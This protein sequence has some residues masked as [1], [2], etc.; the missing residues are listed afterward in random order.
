MPFQGSS[1]IVELRSLACK[2]WKTT[3]SK[4]GG[5]LRPNTDLIAVFFFGV[6]IETALT[7]VP[8]VNLTYARWYKNISWQ[9]I[10]HS[11]NRFHSH[12][13]KFSFLYY[14]DEI[15]QNFEVVWY[16][17]NFKWRALKKLELRFYGEAK[18]ACCKLIKLDSKFFTI[19]TQRSGWQG[20][21]MSNT[22]NE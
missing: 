10:Q 5:E 11:W 3:M 4:V 1:G 19:N 6:F 18:W 20:I 7:S 9:I 22:W 8:P 16:L 13:F 2:S 21:G 12:R 17:D 15:H 14:T